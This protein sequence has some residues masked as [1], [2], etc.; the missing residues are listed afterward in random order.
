MLLHDHTK[1]SDCKHNHEHPSQTKSYC[2]A[3][4][5]TW[6]PF[7]SIASVIPLPAYHQTVYLQLFPSAAPMNLAFPAPPSS[8]QRRRSLPS[9]TQAFVKLADHSIMAAGVPPITQTSNMAELPFSQPHSLHSKLTSFMDPITATNTI[10]SMFPQ[11][12][13]RVVQLIDDSKEPSASDHR[14]TAM[15]VII[16]GI[17]LVVIGIGVLILCYCRRRV[18]HRKSSSTSASTSLLPLVPVPASSLSSLSSTSTSL[19]SSLSLYP[20]QTEDKSS[21]RPLGAPPR[22]CNQCRCRLSNYSLERTLSPPTETVKGW[23][24][25]FDSMRSDRGMCIAME[26]TMISQDQTHAKDPRFVGFHDITATAFDMNFRTRKDHFHNTKEA[27]KDLERQQPQA[28]QQYE[29]KNPEEHNWYQYI[30]KSVVNGDVRWS[31]ALARAWKTLSHPSLTTGSNPTVGYFGDHCKCIVPPISAPPPLMIKETVVE[32]P[33]DVLTSSPC[34]LYTSGLDSVTAAAARVPSSIRFGSFSSLPI[35]PSSCSLALEFQDAVQK[36]DTT[37]PMTNFESKEAFCKGLSSLAPA[38]AITRSYH[39]KNNVLKGSLSNVYRATSSLRRLQEGYK[40]CYRHHRHHFYIKS[41][42]GDKT[43][44]SNYPYHYRYNYYYGYYC[45]SYSRYNRGKRRDGSRK[46]SGKQ[47]WKSLKYHR[48]RDRNS[49]I[50]V[51]GYNIYQINDFNSHLS[52]GNNQSLEKAIDK[53]HSLKQQQQ[54]QQKQQRQQEHQQNKQ[55]V[56]HEPQ[57]QRQQQPSWGFLLQS[58][59]SPYTCVSDEILAPAIFE[60]STLPSHLWRS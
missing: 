47:N 4:D 49:D 46:L 19:L 18:H 56:Q 12:T 14:G 55:Q 7:L 9:P 25:G 43:S 21:H 48:L 36:D 1:S 29:T 51:D 57:R 42:H 22:V 8:S 2:G 10:T 20:A 50:R 52:H 37:T 3:V 11:G 6:R 28:K 5:M 24:S 58:Y 40:D 34:P 23:P 45:H 41:A 53:K 30:V 60:S 59:E 16:S 38:R 27:F 15:I 31:L 54:K 32:F 33:K 26:K 13:H 44:K 17:A 39:S 35:Y